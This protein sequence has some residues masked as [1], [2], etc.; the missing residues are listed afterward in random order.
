M[1]LVTTYCIL[2]GHTTKEQQI[3]PIHNLVIPH[4]KLEIKRSTSINP[5]NM[6][7]FQRFLIPLILTS[8]SAIDIRQFV[9]KVAEQKR[10]LAEDDVGGATLTCLMAALTFGSTSDPSDPSMAEGGVLSSTLGL[11]LGS[12]LFSICPDPASCDIAGNPLYT[13]ADDLC[14]A[15]G[16]QM[17]T[18]DISVCKDTLVTIAESLGENSTELGLD[19][20]TDVNVSNIPVCLPPPPTCPA[21]L[22]LFPAIASVLDLIVGA[23]STNPDSEQIKA[24]VSAVSKILEG[25][26]DCSIESSTETSG[27]G[28]FSSLFLAG[29]LAMGASLFATV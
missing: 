13:Q 25:E 24:V 2:N 3:S 5:S 22:D 4:K 14:S 1:R 28:A 20:V 21:D 10:G 27:S 9:Q 11:V 19:E 26:E 15:A 8:A 29:I 12:D 6:H 23:L 7:T 16:G 17:L 18:T